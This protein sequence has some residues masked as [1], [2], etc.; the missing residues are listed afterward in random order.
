MGQSRLGVL[1]GEEQVLKRELSN[2]KQLCQVFVPEFLEVRF[3]ELGIGDVGEQGLECT[4]V[5]GLDQ[6]MNVGF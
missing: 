1:L 3:G 5:G 2:F 4:D 6:V